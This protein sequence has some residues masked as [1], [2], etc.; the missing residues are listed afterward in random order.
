MINLYKGREFPR[1]FYVAIA[2]ATA[3]KTTIKTK[4]KTEGSD[5]AVTIK[6]RNQLSD[7]ELK[8]ACQLKCVT[9]E[10]RDN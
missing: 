1:Q 3:I 5:Q 4:V 7:A 10:V 2:T 9:I 8:C 6:V